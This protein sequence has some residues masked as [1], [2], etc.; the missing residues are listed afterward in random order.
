[1]DIYEKCYKNGLMNGMVR[2]TLRFNKWIDT[3]DIY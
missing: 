2:M 1:M 3:S